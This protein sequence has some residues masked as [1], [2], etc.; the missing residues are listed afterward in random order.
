M[1]ATLG[2]GEEAACMRLLE[3]AQQQLAEPLPSQPWKGIGAFD[4]GKLTAYRGGD[5]MRLGRYPQAQA[6]LHAAL[7]QLDPAFAKHRC[8]AHIDLAT[9]YLQD[10]KVDEGVEH[11][12]NALDIV[13]VTRHA[14]SL[15]RVEHL[16]PMIRTS[17]IPAARDLRRKLVEIKAAS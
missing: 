4:A 1:H 16:Y 6:E 10:G 7:A 5:L 11:A 3:M 15:R 13:A 8:T 17:G 14:D 2:P 12:V 9:A